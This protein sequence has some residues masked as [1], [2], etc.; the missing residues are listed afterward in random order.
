MKHTLISCLSSTT[1]LFRVVTLS[2]YIRFSSKIFCCNTTRALV[3]IS[4]REL[5]TPVD[6]DA[7]Y[8]YIP[9]PPTTVLFVN[10]DLFF[11]V[12]SEYGFSLI[13]Q[14]VAV[15]SPQFSA[16]FGAANIPSLIRVRYTRGRDAWK[17]KSPY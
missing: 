9:C 8:R 3:L 1:S 16:I 2:L 7:E 6:M 10:P 4:R 14:L 15:F 11:D 12:P 5:Y 13:C 17:T